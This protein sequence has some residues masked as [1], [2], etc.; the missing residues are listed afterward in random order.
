MKIVRT[1]PPYNNEKFMVVELPSEY[2]FRV[3][4]NKTKKE[5]KL[6][7]HERYYI[8]FVAML[9]RSIDEDEDFLSLYSL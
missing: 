8:L 3:V 5:R 2:I 7:A 4:G 1:S 6:K 9:M